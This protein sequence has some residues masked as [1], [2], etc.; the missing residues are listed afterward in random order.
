[1]RRYGLLLRIPAILFF[2]AL[3]VGC[4]GSNAS[5]TPNGP[6]SGAAIPATTAGGSGG[7]GAGTARVGLP[8]APTTLLGTPGVGSARFGGG[9]ATVTIVG[10][11]GAG[12]PAPPG[13]T[14]FID[15]P[16]DGAIVNGPSVPVAFHATGIT[17]APADGA[18]RPGIAHYAVI[19]DETVAFAQP[20]PS[21]A[22]HIQTADGTAM[23]T[24]VSPGRHIIRVVLAN[25]LNMPLTDTR[26]QSSVTITVS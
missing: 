19:L 18:A 7:T 21:D 4:G 22:T 9:D 3:L 16:K 13:P 20:I 23:L 11:A 6:V 8:A 14:V 12:S 25:G 1:M 5:P 17:I 26:A 15:A 10:T 24:G 2:L